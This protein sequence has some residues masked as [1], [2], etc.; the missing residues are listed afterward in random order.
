MISVSPSTTWPWATLW[1]ACC[2]I[3][4][5]TIVAVVA[6]SLYA[7]QSGVGLPVAEI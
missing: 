2:T 5:K 1:Y 4:R 7:E 6:P 3:E